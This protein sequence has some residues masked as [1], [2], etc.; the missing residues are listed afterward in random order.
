MADAQNHHI[1][2]LLHAHDLRV[3]AKRRAVWAAFDNGRAGHLSAEEVLQL[4]RRSAPSVSRAT[5][6]NTL[7]RFVAAGLL[8]RIEAPDCRLYDPNVAPHDHFRCRVC[9][10][11]FDV[12]LQGVDRISPT[13]P[14]YVVEHASVLLDGTCPSCA[15]KR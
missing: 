7:S 6:Y 14:G 2:A 3:T 1:D 13:E 12:Q 15:E 8:A 4:A 5:I 9:S 10:R 11:L